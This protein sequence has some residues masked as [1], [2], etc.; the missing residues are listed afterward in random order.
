MADVHAAEDATPG[1]TWDTCGVPGGPWVEDPWP[2][3]QRA[4][5]VVTHGGQNAL[6]EVA[7]A[8]RP[9]VVVPQARPHGE[10][11]AN[12][13]AVER[14]GL[15]VVERSWPAAGD[16]PEVLDRA[17][18]LDPGRWRTWSDGGGAA[19][20]AAHLEAAVACARR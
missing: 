3:L 1:W 19:R 7:A 6:A 4:G 8:R 12:A 13:R 10:Q 18:A 15:A 17:A 14:G 5:V 11:V 2:L 9:T 20:A 16:W